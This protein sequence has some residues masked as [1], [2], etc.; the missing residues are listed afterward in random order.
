MSLVINSL[1]S[2]EDSNFFDYAF[3]VQLR[4]SYKYEVEVL[5]F[6]NSKM[7]KLTQAILHSEQI[8][9]PVISMFLPFLFF[10]IFLPF[11]LHA[12]SIVSSFCNCELQASKKLSK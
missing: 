5:H 10:A 11:S 12:I 3:D 8:V 1:D 2:F 7:L 9:A 4:H 6:Q